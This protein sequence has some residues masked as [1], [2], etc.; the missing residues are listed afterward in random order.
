MID[1]YPFG[2]NSLTTS[3]FAITSSN[4]SFAQKVSYVNTAS[5]AGTVLNPRTG[6]NASVNICLLTYQQYLLLRSDPSK[7]ENCNFT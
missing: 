7:V 2:A 5:V 6:P 1:V 3:S 4:A